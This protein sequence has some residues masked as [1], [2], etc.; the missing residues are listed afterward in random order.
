MKMTAEAKATMPQNAAAKAAAET[1]VTNYMGGISYTLNPL[2]TLKIITASSIFGEAQYYNDGGKAEAGI[3]K[4]RVYSIDHAF[5][6]YALSELAC[7]EGKNTVEIM[8][9]AI[10]KALDYDFEKTLEWAVKLRK[11]YYMR[12][13]PQIIMVRAAMH[14]SRQEFTSS[15]KG[16]FAD[17]N[18]RVMSRA[19]DPINQLT[20]YLY[21]NGSKNNIPGVLKKSWARK[22][23]S[24]SLYELYKYR[25]HGIG[26]INAIRICHANNENID[27][28][29]RTGTVS[30]E[31]ENKTWE[32]L[33]AANKKWAEIVSSIKMGHMALL[34]NLRG[35][36]SEI[37]DIKENSALRNKILSD[38]ENGVANGKQFPF[39]YETAYRAIEA[40]SKIQHK[41]P[42]LDS[43]ERCI[44]NAC[45]NL[46][47]LEGNNAFLSDNSG[48]AW[49]ACTS[50]YGTATVAEIGNLS[51]VIGAA[52][53]DTG[54][55]FKFGDTLKKYE[56]SRRNGI[57]SQA[58][59]ISEG[60]GFDVGGATECGIWLFFDQAINEKIKYDNIFIYS[61]MQAG[62][63]G[64]Y[65]TSEE[66]KR[67]AKLGYSTNDDYIDVAKLVAAYRKTVNPK[68]NV[69]CVQTA[70]YDNSLLPE[71][72]YRTAILAGWTGKELIYAKTMN[73]FW[74]EKD[75]ENANR[76][77]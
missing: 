14:P 32:T 69:Y 49:G 36:F 6:E 11:D 28:L 62:H 20:Y 72:G 63:G 18:R 60:H 33:R 23:E 66:K 71:N 29:M 57:I 58:R 64:L 75:A 42:I 54:T 39:R 9:D 61:D 19:D 15:H 16:A 65:G 38:L 26:L 17:I 68:V 30:I 51:C 43:L 55:V 24:L 73:D 70:G 59:K 77:S 45:D 21:K 8:E 7:Y 67:Y 47:H 44:D 22:I 35:I 76:Q 3:K 40:E 41:M 31:E 25:N 12:L 46:P 1:A 53:S 34:R 4:A 56:I 27:E 2:D 10:D 37:E 5:Y 13:N 52:N 48:S 74:D 50:E